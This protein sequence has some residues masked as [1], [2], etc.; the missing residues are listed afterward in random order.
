[1]DSLVAVGE[2]IYRREEYDSARLVLSS[3]VERARATDDS[4]AEA[5]ALT[6][7]GLAAWRLGDYAAARA[8]QERAL[9]L[10]LALRLEKELWRSYNGL[11]LVAWN[12]GQLPY[13]LTRFAEATAAAERVGDT[14][15]VGST[16]GNVGLVQTELGNFVAA[17]RDFLRAR[18]IGRETGNGRVEG[19]AHTNLGMLDIRVGDPRAALDHIAAA[20]RLYKTAEYATGRQNALGQMGTAYAALGEPQRALAALDTALAEA[21]ELGVQQDEASD[22]EAMASS[23]ASRATTDGRWSFTLR[24]RRSTRSWGWRSS[25]VPTSAAK[26]RS[27]HS[28]AI[29]G[30]PRGTRVRRS[31]AIRRQ[32][33]VS[34]SWPTASFWRTSRTA[35]GSESR[36]MRTW[37]PRE[38]SLERSRLGSPA[39]LW[40][41]ARRGSP[42]AGASRAACSPR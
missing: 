4:V 17:R 35:P 11:G 5:R 8:A 32:A 24:R 1:V 39:W 23:I 14:V 31:V 13:A 36:P 29:W 28:S 19:N 33:H 10:K 12:E 2:Q 6:W 15:G 7:L 34:S 26:P 25:W 37:P 42:I 9:A 30:W 41:S 20:L 21:R 22:L 18:D 38:A 3:V 40:R 27:T 16:A